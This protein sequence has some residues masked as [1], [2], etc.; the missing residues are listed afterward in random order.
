MQKVHA[1][2]SLNVPS[3]GERS[4]IMRKEIP[5][6]ITE[7]GQVTVPAEV[8]DLLGVR[9]RGPVNWVIEDG[10]VRLQRP[11]LTL[12]DAFGSIKPKNRP[13]DWEKRIR[14]AKEERAERLVKKMRAS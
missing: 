4:C 5:G 13:E 11:R 6:T 10:T 3:L 14:E 7:R 12:E 8:R 2:C 1:L 9:K